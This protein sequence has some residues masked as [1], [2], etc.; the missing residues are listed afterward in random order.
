MNHIDLTGK[1]AVITGGA[2]ASA[3]PSPSDSWHQAQWCLSGT[4]TEQ[5]SSRLPQSYRAMRGFT[6]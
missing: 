5:S 2:R 3:V 4:A 1:R 6:P